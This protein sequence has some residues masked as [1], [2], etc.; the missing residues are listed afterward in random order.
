MVA[1]GSN[2]QGQLNIPAG[3]SKI[4]KMDGRGK[5]IFVLYA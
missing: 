1:W 4:Q 3:L 5:S 2:A